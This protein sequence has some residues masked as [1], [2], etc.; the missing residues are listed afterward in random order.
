MIEKQTG[1]Q[2]KCLRTNNGLKFCYDEFN[3]QC[4]KEQIDRRRTIR[5]TPQ[6]N[7]MVELMNRTLIEKV[8]CMLSNV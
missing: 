3:T 8:K 4:K 7:G 6:Q 5:H 2:M 1:R